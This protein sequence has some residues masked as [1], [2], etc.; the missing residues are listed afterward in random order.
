MVYKSIPIV[1]IKCNQQ[2][3]Q[4]EEKYYLTI[5]AF[6]LQLFY[7]SFSK[8]GTFSTYRKMASLKSSIT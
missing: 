3:Q 8:V 2:H 7:S 6:E 5:D 4:Q 1:I